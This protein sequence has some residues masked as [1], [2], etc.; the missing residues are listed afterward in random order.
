[1]FSP[2]LVNTFTWNSFDQNFKNL[3]YYLILGGHAFLSEL[4]SKRLHGAPALVPKKAKMFFLVEY[5]IKKV[6]KR[7]KTKLQST[8]LII[9]F[10]PAYVYFLYQMGNPF[11]FFLARKCWGAPIPPP[12]SKSKMWSSSAFWPRCVEGK[13]KIT[14]VSKRRTGVYLWFV[15][16][17]ANEN[18]I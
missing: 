15:Y 13:S 3:L 16:F 17:F 7:A 6:H 8:F 14:S 1:M 4:A 9:I 5:L 18:F 10:F 11:D 12:P 2:E